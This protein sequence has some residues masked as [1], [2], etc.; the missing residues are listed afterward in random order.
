LAAPALSSGCQKG[1]SLSSLTPHIKAHLIG[2]LD[3]S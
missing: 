2:R 3:D 1:Q